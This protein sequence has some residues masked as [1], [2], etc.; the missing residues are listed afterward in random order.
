MV[1][2]KVYVCMY[3]YVY[4]C[5][6][7]LLCGVWCVTHLS[8]IIIIVYRSLMCDTILTL[9]M[10]LPVFIVHIWPA[11]TGKQTMIPPGHPPISTTT[12]TTTTVLMPLLL[13]I[14][15]SLVCCG[16]LEPCLRDGMMGKW[17]H[18][19]TDRTDRQRKSALPVWK[20][21]RTVIWFIGLG[22]CCKP[23]VLLYFVNFSCLGWVSL[24]PPPSHP[25]PLIPHS[26]FEIWLSP[27]AS[28][29]AMSQ[30]LQL[31]PFHV[32]NIAFW[33]LTSAERFV[34]EER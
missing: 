30:W 13:L 16:G 26:I 7:V 20:M 2:V 10:P 3:V 5:W 23:D 8:C 12:T 28:S 21:M 24:H 9:A 11:V 34:F 31:T 29:T 14:I 19:G 4:V 27:S 33:L 1:N 17:V 25:S 22:T 6:D 18:G 32:Q 15:P